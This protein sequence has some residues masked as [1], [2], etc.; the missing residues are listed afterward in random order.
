M[1]QDKYLTISVFKNSI[2]DARTYFARVGAELQMHFSKLGSRLTELDAEERLKILFD[3]Y[4][5]G[6]ESSF[7]FDMEDYAKKGHSFKD[8]ISP[9]SIEVSDD[10]FMMGE[11]YGRVM[12]LKD[13][14]TYLKDD[15]VTK[16]TDISRNLKIYLPFLKLGLLKGEEVCVER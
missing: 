8:Y 5:I 13:Y 16:L 15:I 2:E 1:V 4:R 14:A 12:F 11:K 9:D 3:F 7:S 10:F 6:E